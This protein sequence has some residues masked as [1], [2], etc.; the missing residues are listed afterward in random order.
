MLAAVLFGKK[1]VSLYT[2]RKNQTYVSMSDFFASLYYYS[3]K[4]MPSS[5]PVDDISAGESYI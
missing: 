2:Y 5:I 4:S 3:S 1:S